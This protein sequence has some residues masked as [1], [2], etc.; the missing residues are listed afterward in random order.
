MKCKLVQI[1]ASRLSVLKI[2]NKVQISLKIHL[3]L[4]DSR[5][6]ENKQRGLGKEKDHA[7]KQWGI[8]WYYDHRNPEM[9][10]A[11]NLN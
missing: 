4:Q 7:G 1:N 10:C 9:M 6:T 3:Y 8:N 2:S 11:S 5:V